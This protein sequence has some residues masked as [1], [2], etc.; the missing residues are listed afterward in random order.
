M[1]GA[2][3]AGTGAS[4]LGTTLVVGATVVA[5]SVVVLARVVVV[6][7]T[8]VVVVVVVLL[9][10]VE[11]GS[12]TSASPS[13]RPHPLST[14]VT[15]SPT[16]A[17]T[18]PR[19]SE[20]RCWEAMELL[21]AVAMLA[22]AAGAAVLASR[23]EPHWCAPDGRSFTCRVQAIRAD[24]Q[25]DGRWVAAR[26]DVGGGGVSIRASVAGLRDGSSACRPVI[27]RAAGGPKG[28]AV[29]LLGGAPALALRVP[30]RSPAAAVLDA[31]VAR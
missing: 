13:S 17:A 14:S 12:G 20:R 10:T 25:P 7:R 30:A 21:W 16:A 3:V 28:R 1:A 18:C 26:A 11:L 23:I 5:A 9:A 29:F 2:G 4:V 8:V 31:S 15:T 22:V 19:R 24:G 27:G 6:R